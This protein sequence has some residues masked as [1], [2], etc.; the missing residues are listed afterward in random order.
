MDAMIWAGD[1]FRNGGPGAE[2]ILM[3]TD[4]VRIT[5]DAGITTILQDGNHTTLGKRARHRSTTA[6]FSSIPNVEVVTKPELLRVG[7]GGA[8]IVAV[9]WLEKN[10]VLSELGARDLGALEGDARVASYIADTIEDLVDECDSTAPLLLTSHI[11]VDDVQLGL[12]G[13][14]SEQDMTHVFDEPILPRALVE[15]AGFAYAALGHIHDRQS[16]G[17]V[18]HYSG[19]PNRL[20]KTD[21]GKVKGAN[22]VT[23]GD[24]NTL[25]DVTLVET[26]ARAMGVVDL[27]HSSA[28]EQ[29]GALPGGGLLWLTLPEGE[30]AVP[31]EVKALI[32]AAGLSLMGTE[33]T[34]R[35]ASVSDRVALAETVTDR[36]ALVAWLTE[37]GIDPAR[38]ARYLSAAQDLYTSQDRSWVAA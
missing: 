12:H 6:L 27:A 25:L 23:I 15:D 30:T 21:A 2:A 32:A 38:H 11:T 17:A 9:P 29:I 33:T 7:P 8:Q 13:R 5:A 22:L 4:I 31:P 18:C 37:R 10:L 3:F 26:P 14:G 36:D 1:D 20:T 16:I 24:D 34:H 35:A 19:S 28:H